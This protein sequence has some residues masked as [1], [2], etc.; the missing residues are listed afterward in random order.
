QRDHAAA[1]KIRALAV[2]SVPVRAGIADPPIREVQIRIVRSGDPHGASARLPRVA[3]PAFETGLTR[4]GNG[5]KTPGFL[6]RLRVERRHEPA[7]AVFAARR[8]DDHFVF[9]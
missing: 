7:D 5:V 9:D 3:G 2:V 6:S 1:V 8:A 4:A